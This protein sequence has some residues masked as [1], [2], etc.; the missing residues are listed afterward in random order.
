[1]SDRDIAIKFNDAINARDLDALVALMTDDHRFVDTEGTVFEGIDGC[2]EIWSGFFSAFPDYRN[3]FETVTDR[4]GTVVIAGRSTCSDARLA[5]PAL[6]SVLIAGGAV[7]EWRVHED[8]PARR[9]ELGL[10]P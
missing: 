9:A 3:H 10:A 4:D 7:R 2:R 5:G 8:T 6:W 1:M